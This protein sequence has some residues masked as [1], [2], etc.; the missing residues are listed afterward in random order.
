MNYG[1][2]YCR[3]AK[4]H[5]NDLDAV[6]TELE[7]PLWVWEWK[8]SFLIIMKCCFRVQPICDSTCAPVLRHIFDDRA[9]VGLLLRRPQDSV[10][11]MYTSFSSPAWSWI[12]REGVSVIFC[13]Q[14]WCVEMRVVAMFA[15]QQSA[16]TSYCN[17]S[18]ITST[19]WPL[20]LPR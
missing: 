3:V 12:M 13:G 17:V 11:G 18:I 2:S 16:E 1:M 20:W 14:L 6:S 9:A 8:S 7:A 15:T 4:L 5:K 10:R 19:S